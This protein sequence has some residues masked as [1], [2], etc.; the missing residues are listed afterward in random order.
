MLC[1]LP[2]SSKFWENTSLCY[3]ASIWSLKVCVWFCYLIFEFV[4]IKQLGTS[5]PRTAE[6]HPW[7]YYNPGVQKISRL[8]N[9]FIG[10]FQPTHSSNQ[11]PKDL[12]GR[13]TSPTI[14]S[15]KC[16]HLTP[17]ISEPVSYLCYVAFGST[18]DCVQ[19]STTSPPAN[20]YMLTNLSAEL[21]RYPPAIPQ[22]C[23]S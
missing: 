11:T 13:A 19:Y 10:F 7:G 4:T 9:H 16:S 23:A 1:Q 18:H 21:T 17:A 12:H 22:F 15:H 8:L 20:L 2:K 5:S 6:Q 14:L 3:M